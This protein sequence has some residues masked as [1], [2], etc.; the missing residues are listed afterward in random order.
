[1]P[2]SDP[3]SRTAGHCPHTLRSTLAACRRDG[4]FT[5]IELLVVVAIVALA[6]ALATLAIRDPNAQRLD[7]EAARLTALLEQARA[8][9]RTTGVAV[10]WAPVRSSE[11]PPAGAPPADFRFDGLNPALRLPTRWLDP[12]TS[13]D[14]AGARALRLGPEPFIG[15]QRVL[16]RLGDRRLELST[17][18]L[19]PFTVASGEDAT[20]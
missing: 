16:L 12:A 2:T 8:E 3:G 18:G 13:A 6:S 15:P 10:S 17:D 14:L 1:M 20:P 4:G 5:L 9:S 19:G 11:A 7:Q